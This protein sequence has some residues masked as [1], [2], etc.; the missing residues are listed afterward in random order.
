ML[1]FPLMF[2]LC[3][4]ANKFVPVFYGD[5]FEIVSILICVISPILVLISLSNLVGAQYILLTKQQNKYTLSVIIGAVVNFI[6]NLILIGRLQSVGTSIATVIAE[7]AITATQLILVKDQIKFTDM[8][9]I[10]YKYFI[11]AAIMFA[12]SLG[13]STLISNNFLSTFLPRMEK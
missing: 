9:K 13:I 4:I 10:G 11:A 1:T 6:L 3:G 7:L 2:G 8:I 12:C 5:G